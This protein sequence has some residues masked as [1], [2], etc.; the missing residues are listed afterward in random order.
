MSKLF[1]D[2]ILVQ[3]QSPTIE[4]MGTNIP[5]SIVQSE[6]NSILNVEKTKSYNGVD[7]YTIYLTNGNTFEYNVTNGGI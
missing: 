6:I 2:S 3:V 5:Q 1:V 7:T 4:M